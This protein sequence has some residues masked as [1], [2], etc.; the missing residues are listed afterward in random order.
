MKISNFNEFNLEKI[1][2]L[3]TE[4]FHDKELI[5]PYEFLK[6][7]GYE[8]HIISD[9]EG[10]IKA[11]NSSRKVKVDDLIQNINSDSYIALIIPGGEAPSKL[12]GK[13]QV[14]KFVNGFY[15]ENKL[16]AAIC[17]GPQILIDLGIVEGKQMTGFK[18]I[19]NELI[20]AGVNYKDKSVV[21]D[22]NIIT[23]RNPDDLNNFCKEI[24]KK[25]NEV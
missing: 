6:G 13:K 24:N 8:C 20:N 25:L 14:N 10:I 5:K 15:K 12:R 16:I 3:T 1:A 2:F 23:S 9:K 7:K 22:S 18:D 4:G 21:I 11:Y 19:R 17:H